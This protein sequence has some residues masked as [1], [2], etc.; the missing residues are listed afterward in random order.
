MKEGVTPPNSTSGDVSCSLTSRGSGITSGTSKAILAVEGATSDSSLVLAVEGATSDSSLVACASSD[1]V[2]A[3]AAY[4]FV[5]VGSA[6]YDSRFSELPISAAID[7]ESS[8]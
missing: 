7:A 8:P 6:S 1:W 3:G 4:D 2:V 5:P